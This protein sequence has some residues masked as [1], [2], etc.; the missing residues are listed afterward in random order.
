MVDKIT[1]TIL[2]TTNTVVLPRYFRPQ[3]KQSATPLLRFWAAIAYSVRFDILSIWRQRVGSIDFFR[4][5][6]KTCVGLSS[7]SPNRRP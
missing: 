3:H 1:R 5:L 7:E 2:R 4:P 6:A